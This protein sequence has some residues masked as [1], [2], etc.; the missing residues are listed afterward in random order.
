[1][2]D[3]YFQQAPPKSTG[4]EYFNQ[5][6]LQQFNVDALPA[7]NVQA[8]LCELT[9]ATIADAILASASK[10]DRVLICGGGVHNAYCLQRLQSYLGDTPVESTENHGVPPDWVEAMALAWL[11]QCN[12]E[13]IPGNLPSVTG[14][15]ESVV[16]GTL[17]TPDI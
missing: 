17:S 5:D 11:A 12:L 8:T 3:D 7:E 4:F 15:G 16:L 1:M 13:Q 9:A 2:T 6:W 10:T 14:A